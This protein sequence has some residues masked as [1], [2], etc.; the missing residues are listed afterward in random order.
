MKGLFKRTVHVA[1]TLLVLLN[2]G[3]YFVA[4]AFVAL[5]DSSRQYPR[6]AVHMKSKV[7][8]LQ[9]LFV[10]YRQTDHKG[11]VETIIDQF[12]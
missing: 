1:L 7:D 10:R 11:S 9:K 4:L 6:R 2:I 8:I 5:G 12:L 3:L